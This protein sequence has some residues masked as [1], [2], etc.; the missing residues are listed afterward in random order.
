MSDALLP[1]EE[2]PHHIIVVAVRAGAYVPL[3]QW[4][5]ADQPELLDA[6]Q[7]DLAL[8]RALVK[9]LAKHLD[10]DDHPA[11]RV[12]EPTR[13]AVCAAALPDLGSGSDAVAHAGTSAQEAGA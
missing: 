7:R 8:A 5:M 12:A 1:D 4:R 3:A 11:C 13:E 2:R 10:R 9:R 6:G